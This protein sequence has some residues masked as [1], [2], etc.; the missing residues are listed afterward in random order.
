MHVNCKT[1]GL[2]LSPD[3]DRLQL[4]CVLQLGLAR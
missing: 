3:S 2:A 4:S 1:D